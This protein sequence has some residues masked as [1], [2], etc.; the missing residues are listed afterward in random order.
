M[1][2]QSTLPP[3]ASVLIVDDD[4]D[5]ALTLQDLLEY[6]GYQVHSVPT[7][8]EAI[9]RARSAHFGA[10]ILD[11]GLPDL[12]G[13]SVLRK[14]TE[15]DPKLPVII[16][17]AF[18]KDARTIESLRQGAF[19]YLT[20]PYNREEVKATLRR[21]IGVQALAVKAERV[22]RALNESQE[23]FRSVVET[24][25]DAI[26]LAD[27]TGKI[28]SW[29]KAA[30]AL[31]GYAPD[32]VLG[33]PLTLIMP[34]RYRAAHLKGFERLRASGSPQLIGRTVELHGLRK[35][36]REFPLELSLGTWRTKEGAF[37]SGIIRDISQRRRSE[38][39]LRESEE[40]F[41]QLAENIREVFWM[42]DP[43][44][45]RMIYI[46]PG[47]EQIWGRTCA[48]LY[49]A[50]RSWLDAIHPEDHDRIAEAALTKQTLGTYD[51]EYRILRPD[52]SVRLVRD[53]AFPIRDNAGTVYRIAGIADDITERKSPGQTT[54]QG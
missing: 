12:D 14:L 30:Q 22:E 6:E 44:K 28:V 50:P 16:L 3:S 19:A 51:E 45:N 43:V 25:S 10:V 34:A 17:T 32:E 49:A 23:R 39:A 21:A 38:E 9:A 13:L 26:V 24:A 18:L 8:G 36:G 5:I 1:G 37:Y 33:E 53:R 7:G 4:P 52:G 35:D 11:L 15:D 31:F 41:R 27:Q 29:N 2:G 40:R 46:S 48:S 42:T 47:Y 54:T 20:K